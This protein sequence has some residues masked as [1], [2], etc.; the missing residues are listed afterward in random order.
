MLIFQAAFASAALTS[1]SWAEPAPQH[2]LSVFGDLK[3]GP[4]FTHFDYVNPTAPK[5]GPIKLRDIDSFDS[6]N[7][8]L[9]K[10]KVGIVNGDIGGKTEYTFTQLMTRSLDEPDAVYGLLAE[11]AMVDEKG[12]WVEF[13]LRPT[14]RFHD[15]SQITA[16]D[17][18]F[19]FETLKT[20]GHPRYRFQ[21]RDI[22]DAKVLS[23]L[24]IR[25]EFKADAL[26]RDL[27]RLVAVM[28]ILSDLSTFR[29]FLNTMLRT[30]S[31]SPS[32][33]KTT[34]L[35]SD[36]VPNPKNESTDSCSCFLSITPE[37]MLIMLELVMN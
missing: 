31:N 29:G 21:Y 12:H 14:A 33:A 25:F 20:E 11:T 22:L 27:P 2:G 15:G 6:L 10:G 35:G 36:L 9:L 5:G 4:N 28:P 1:V 19:T 7:P 32:R 17:V 26:T 24:K 13:N 8:F 18:A 16:E 30:A 3:Y 37:S 23:S 34:I